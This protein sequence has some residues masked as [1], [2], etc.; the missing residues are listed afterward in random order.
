MIRPLNLNIRVVDADQVDTVNVF[1]GDSPSDDT[2]T[3]T[4]DRLTG[5]GMGA[6]SIIDGRRFVGGITYGNVEA[7]NIQLGTGNDTLTIESTHA[8]TTTVHGDRGNDTF[9]VKTIAGHTTLITGA[10]DDVVRVANDEGTVDQITGL[11]T[12][13]T[14]AGTDT[15]T[16]D[17]S[18]DTNDNVA[19]VT[20]TTLT[21]LDMP[22][23][24][25]VFSVFVRALSGSYR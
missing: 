4:S 12:I 21:G 10:G 24:A 18:A 1:N 5:L 19:T 20:P 22:T 14:G 9:H 2:G 3:L 8:G 16:V 11:L 25:Q 23:V 7:L 13:D 15:V 17:D 6:E